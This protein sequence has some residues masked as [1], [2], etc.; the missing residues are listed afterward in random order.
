MV[1][2][3][4]SN[5][6]IYNDAYSSDFQFIIMFSPEIFAWNSN[7]AS[8]AA[9][10][11][12]SG[13]TAPDPSGWPSG[14]DAVHWYDTSTNYFKLT[15]D[16]GIT[17]N[18]SHVSL[19]IA[20]IIK[21]SAD[22][23]GVT[24]INQI[25][26]GFSHYGR[27]VFGLPGVKGL[28]PNGK[29]PDGTL[30]NIEVELDKVTLKYISTGY[31][32]TLDMAWVVGNDFYEVIPDFWQLDNYTNYMTYQNT[33]SSHLIFASIDCNG[34]LTAVNFQPK[35]V[36]ALTD[37]YST[38]PVILYKRPFGMNMNWYRLY[39]SGWVEQG[40]TLSNSDGSATLHTITL[41]IPMQNTYYHASRS[42]YYT[43]SNHDPYADYITGIREKTT[44][45]IKI[46]SDSTSYTTNTM[47]EVRGWSTYA[48]GT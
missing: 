17:W 14:K 45:T 42:N 31:I 35:Q 19:P 21:P 26:N 8:D 28:V 20:T 22:I 7:F 32:G 47:W 12:Y 46:W 38:D 33:H 48:R 36:C 4:N 6:I 29:N 37:M 23:N 44:T 15:I 16:R 11:C 25:Y 41:P 1:L 24:N 3:Q 2:L 43:G 13:P 40:G 9:S 30:R 18:I 5:D 27:T 39:R 10:Y 34:E